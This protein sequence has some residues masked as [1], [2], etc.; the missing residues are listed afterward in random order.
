MKHHPFFAKII[1]CLI[2]QAVFFTAVFSSVPVQAAPETEKESLRLA[3]PGWNTLMMEDFEGEFPNGLWN[4]YD[5]D[6][7]T[8][9]EYYWGKVDYEPADGARAVPSASAWVAAA[10]ADALDPED[11]NYPNYALSRM[12]YGPFNLTG[13]YQAELL[14]DYW[15]LSESGCDYFKWQASI[16]GE[17]YYGRETSGNDSEW[18]NVTLDLTDV[19]TLG[20]ITGQ[21]QVWIAFEFTSD[22]I[23]TY[24]G[25]FVD[26]IVL[27]AIE[28]PTTPP[29]DFQKIAPV[30]M[31]TSQP[32]MLE[33]TWE[34]SLGVEHYEVCVDQDDDDTC[35]ST[36]YS[37]TLTS[38]VISPLD[39]QTTYYWQVQAVNVVM[40]T[41][42]NG[43]E[44]WSFTTSAEPPAGFSKLG[45]ADG[46]IDQGV[47]QDVPIP[48]SASLEISWEASEGTDSYEYC[49]DKADAVHPDDNGECDSGWIDNGSNITTTLAGLD[50]G[51]TYYWQARSTH[52]DAIT[53][54]NDGAWWSFTTIPHVPGNFAK[55]SP[56]NG[57]AD[58]YSNPILSWAE[59]AGVSAGYS[60]GYEYCYA[61]LSPGT[62]AGTAPYTEACWIDNGV[63][64]SIFLPAL[65]PGTTYFWNVRAVNPGGVT[66]ADN[67][68]G[69]VSTPYT[70]TLRAPITWL[71]TN[72]NDSGDGSL[73]QAI[74]YAA[75]GETILFDPILAG[76]VISLTSELVVDRNLIID[77]SGLYPHLQISGNDSVRV[78]FVGN[79]VTATLRNLEI[80]NGHGTNGGGIQNSGTLAV[81]NCTLAHNHAWETGGG[82][83]NSGVLTITASAIYSNTATG[84]D[85]ANGANGAAGSYGGYDG[86]DGGAG[87]TGSS[88]RGGG[89]FN[90]GTLYMAN[91]TLADNQAA[92]GTGGMG[93]AGGNGATGLMG[94][95]GSAGLDAI[96]SVP[97][98]FARGG[99]GGNGGMGKMGGNGGNG[100]AGGTGGNGQGGGLYSAGIS[101]LVN[102]TMSNNDTAA[103]AAGTGGA[104]GASGAGGMGG[105]GGMPG[106]CRST[107]SSCICSQGYPGLMGLPGSSGIRGSSGSSGYSGSTYG[108]GL[109]GSDGI[110]VTLRSSLFALNAAT[111]GVDGFGAAELEGANLFSTV[112]GLTLQ[113]DIGA[114][115]TSTTPM[116]GPLQDNGGP[117][118]TQALLSGTPQGS[119]AID[120]CAGYSAADPAADARGF[121][122]P[123][124][125]DQDGNATCDLG[126]YEFYPP[127]RVVSVT[128]LDLDPCAGY[129]ACP[130]NAAS[131]RFEVRFN[132]EVS[133]VDN[134][135]FNPSAN[136]P[137]GASVSAVEPQYLAAQSYTVTVNTGSGDGTLGLDVLDD[138]SILNLDNSPLGGVGVDNGAYTTGEAYTIDKTPP[139][140]NII[141][142]PPALTNAITSTL[143]FNSSEAGAIFE[144]RLDDGEFAGGCASPKDYTNLG[145]GAHTFEV[146]SQDA[147]GNMDTSPAAYT[148]T[149]DTLAPDTSITSHPPVL[150]NATAATL[151]F[152]S[153]EA[154]AAFE[155]QLN[156]GGFAACPSPKDYT[157]LGEGSH[158]F[159]VRSMDA[160]GNTDASPAAYTWRVDT[161]APDTSITAHPLALTNA[162]DATLAFSSTEAGAAFECQLDGGGFAACPSPKGYTN[163]GE[164]AHT[165]EVRSQD[166]AGNIDASPAI[167]IWIIDIAAP[168]V[169]SVLRLGVSPTN[170]ASVIFIV[171][172]SEGVSGVDISDFNLVTSGLSGTS[173]VNMTGAGA[174]YTVTV[175]AGSGDG[176]LRL[177]VLDNDSI[178][179]AAGG[180]LGGT[181]AGNGDYSLGEAYTLD[182]TAPDTSLTSQ[183][184]ALS[185]ATGAELAFTSSEAGSTFEC[186]LD[187]GAFITCTNPK[188]YTNLEEG[189]HTFEVRSQDA[190]G[191]VDASP[192][193]YTWTVDLTAPTG[194]VTI[195]AG[196]A[197]TASAQVTLSLAA[198][199]AGSGVTFVQVRNAG[200]AWGAWLAYSPS[201]S[202]TLPP[203]AGEKTVDVRY[204]D[205]AGNVSEVYSDTILLTQTSYFVY[206]PV[207]IR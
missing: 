66:Y 52:L 154:G 3:V 155:C 77:A 118:F 152:S 141:S 184:P 160:A 121:P 126:A 145:E 19:P 104:G 197:E 146:R 207:A 205:A 186:R 34:S 18:Y 22:S 202:W 67:D 74:S 53:D 13:Y 46:D 206:L 85:G 92:G 127:P 177:D 10:G 166:A 117:V 76:Q 82:I 201:M 88:G 115:I 136:G 94:G 91:T 174:T 172:F 59:S 69:G 28:T 38:T 143:V 9:G 176:T 98:G 124:D 37:N 40:T 15:L 173:L 44:W 16:D 125:G 62:D 198:S 187:G 72:A 181:G 169:S 106:S 41:T 132:Q 7:T 31:I 137:V 123:Q 99:N 36:W 95:A 84:A 131:V 107:V 6:G 188:V 157:N 139:E 29:G 21:P 50:L 89:V 102:V 138:D 51:T 80:R 86:Y 194:S 168:T 122:R 100:G 151:A 162:T 73:R 142:H 39:P 200:G 1:S 12:E 65:I 61:V 75:Q 2:I 164:G 63:D 158:T 48:A 167:Y 68:V 109:Y 101:M 119:P 32:L 178:L 112:A 4:A 57:A 110:T 78:F 120:A 43:G 128:R 55:T 189:A 150:A 180:K 130:S 56:A 11:W 111:L 24:N 196:A 58:V 20:D 193:A 179:D 175:D 79:G 90:S 49:F 192:A 114:V 190:V 26:N 159:E 5:M 96:C 183:P 83:Y 199:D 35:N 116:L 185:N 23:V 45:P 144:C 87:E 148:W 161:L 60:G 103:G 93:G 47:P 134:T 163:L 27:R 191:N 170:A 42:A 64:A 17:N 8:N 140:T 204:Q 71:V 33:L 133:G 54:A 156:G 30:D 129:S 70:F 81:E 153:T 149:V 203:A 14:F 25:A 113:G 97:Y 108:G 171:S 182:R 135:D 195:N 165:F 147:A 105:M